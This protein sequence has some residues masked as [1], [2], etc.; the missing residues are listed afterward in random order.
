MDSGGRRRWRATRWFVVRY[1]LLP[2]LVGL[3]RRCMM[4]DDC[5]LAANIPST[6]RSLVARA[7]SLSRSHPIVSRHLTVPSYHFRRHDVLVTDSPQLARINDAAAQ[8]RIGRIPE[9][10]KGVEA[11]FVRGNRGVRDQHRSLACAPRGGRSCQEQR[12]IARLWVLLII[13]G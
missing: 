5:Y 11:D 1:S 8:M 12:G 7:P 4:I 10:Y 9:D 6:A 2:S 3:L 13:R